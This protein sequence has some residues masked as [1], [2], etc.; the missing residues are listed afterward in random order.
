MLSPDLALDYYFL[1]SRGY[2]EKEAIQTVKRR[3]RVTRELEKLVKR[4]IHP[5]SHNE[6]VKRKLVEFLPKN[7]WVCIDGYNQ[8][9]TVYAALSRGY[10]YRCTDGLLRDDLLGYGKTEIDALEKIM[11][12]LVLEAYSLGAEKVYLVL[13]SRVPRSG[14]LAARLRA[15]NIRAFTSRK[16]DTTLMHYS[17]RGCI[18]ASS[19]KVVV[20]KAVE[21]VDLASNLLSRIRKTFNVKVINVMDVVVKS[22]KEWCTNLAIG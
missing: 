22:A 6:N 13:D 5:P 17:W 18:V 1:R 9:L 11:L 14:Q 20:E 4:C 19:D 21:V 12:A 7:S 10:V 16:A 3:Y 8:A 15:Y 2:S